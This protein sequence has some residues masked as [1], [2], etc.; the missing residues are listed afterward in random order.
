MQ[1]YPLLPILSVSPSTMAAAA[2]AVATMAR[3]GVQAA[4]TAAKPA[5]T[6]ISKFD[7]RHGRKLVALSGRST[8]PGQIGAMVAD[9]KDHDVYTSLSDKTQLEYRVYL[10][11]FVDKFGEPT[12]GVWRPDRCDRGC[13]STAKRTAGPARTRCTGRSAPSSA[14]SGSAM[15]GSTIQASCHRKR[16]LR[17]SSTLACR[18]QT[19]S[20]GRVRRSTL[21]CQWPT[22][23]AQVDRRRHRDDG[24]AGRA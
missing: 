16:T 4:A 1:P 21:S 5:N 15:T 23:L 20:S 18:S 11:K 24:L 17:P 8:R 12:G 9:Y 3:G 13:E 19:S 14:R 2:D 7:R 10:D 6:R 22:K